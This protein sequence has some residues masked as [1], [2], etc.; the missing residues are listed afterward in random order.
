MPNDILDHFFD[1]KY[2]KERTSIM[3]IGY[4]ALGLSADELL[5]MERTSNQSSIYLQEVSRFRTN[6][7]KDGPL[8]PL[9]SLRNQ[10]SEQKVLSADQTYGIAHI[11]AKM[12]AKNIANE[13]LPSLA[14]P[15]TFVQTVGPLGS[16]NPITPAYDLLKGAKVFPNPE[17]EASV[18]KQL[19]VS[20]ELLSRDYGLESTSQMQSRSNHNMSKNVNEMPILIQ[21]SHNKKKK[22]SSYCVPPR[23]VSCLRSLIVPVDELDSQSED[24]KLETEGSAKFEV[25]KKEDSLLSLSKRS[26]WASDL[27]L[28]HHLSTLKQG[29]DSFM[30][31]LNHR[32]MVY[33]L[34]RGV[35]A[36]PK[37]LGPYYRVER[38]QPDRP[39]QDIPVETS[40]LSFFKEKSLTKAEATLG[41]PV[42]ELSREKSKHNHIESE[43]TENSEVKITADGS[44]GSLSK[45][46][47]WKGRDYSRFSP[48]SKK[49]SN[50]DLINSPSRDRNPPK[51][52]PSQ[53]VA[54]Y[55]AI[56]SQAQIIEKG[57]E[58][59]LQIKVL[60]T[61]N[62]EPARADDYYLD[63]IHEDQLNSEDASRVHQNQGE[64]NLDLS[65]D[66][67]ASLAYSKK[68]TDMSGVKP[69]PSR[70]DSK[71]IKDQKEQE[72]DTAV[73]RRENRIPKQAY[74]C[75]PRLVFLADGTP[76]SNSV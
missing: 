2:K 21:A 4:Q 11:S 36:D 76:F 14:K 40:S 53:L 70:E 73:V 15:K 24:P 25:Q 61:D 26:L 8:K 71:Q 28:H 46:S 47:G 65:H 29:Y 23:Y 12:F 20:K 13:M 43:K 64:A 72:V 41:N 38:R 33:I 67:S 52:M 75:T 74:S 30:S 60:P 31:K 39:S 3:S 6:C 16:Q 56:V 54:F 57:V 7:S 9:K 42:I 66:V 58:S 49:I 59:P 5:S 62:T 45:K 37:H 44:P 55:D 18:D 34:P 51:R 50:R 48:Q 63:N 17:L 1:K 32:S 69:M 10:K 19:S 22:K 27:N 35:I 68:I